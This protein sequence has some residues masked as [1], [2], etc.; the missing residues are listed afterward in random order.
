[1]VLVLVLK[2]FGIVYITGVENRSGPQGD[3]STLDPDVDTT[4]QQPSVV[5]RA[6][7]SRLSAISL[8]LPPPASARSLAASAS[9]VPINRVSS[10]TYGRGGAPTS[11]SADVADSEIASDARQQHQLQLLQPPDPQRQYLSVDSSPRLSETNSALSTPASSR[12]S[13]LVYFTRSV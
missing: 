6:L 5:F 9:S 13:S 11:T 7:R 10:L 2:E 12:G 1:M 8:G 3:A 4:M